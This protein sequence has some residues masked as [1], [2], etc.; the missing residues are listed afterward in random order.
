MREAIV[1]LTKRRWISMVVV[2]MLAF[3]SLIVSWSFQI[4]RA[5]YFGGQ[6]NFIFT[7]SL[8]AYKLLELS[9]LSYFLFYRHRA[10]LKRNDLTAEF[11]VTLKKHVKLLLFLIPQGNTVF[12]IIAYKLSGNVL[13]F[14][15]FSLIALLTLFIINPNSLKVTSKL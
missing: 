6:Y 1:S 10:Y 13:Y 8:I 9:L 3:I 15:I 5:T 4:S 12:G 14:L 2:V 7:Y 11:V